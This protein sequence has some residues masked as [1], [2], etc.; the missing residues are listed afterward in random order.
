MG[1]YAAE[2]GDPYPRADGPVATT[3][4]SRLHDKARVGQHDLADAIAGELERLE[5][6][7]LHDK[8]TK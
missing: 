7:I 8:D 4:R 1:H 3:I 6:M 5:R 2:M